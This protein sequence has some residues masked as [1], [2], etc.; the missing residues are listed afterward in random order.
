MSVKQSVK[1]VIENLLG[2]MKLIPLIN[3]DEFESND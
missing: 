3:I 2:Q 1:V